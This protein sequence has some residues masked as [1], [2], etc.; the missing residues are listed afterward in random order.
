MKHLI[1]GIDGGTRRILEAYDMPFT[2]SL[3]S[4]AHQFNTSDEDLFS[5]GWAEMVLGEHAAETR[6]FYMAPLM[7]GSTGFSIK[8]KTDE[9]EGLGYTPIWRAAEQADLKVGIMNIPTTS[10]AKTVN[11]FMIGSGGGGVNKVSGIPDSLVY[12]PSAKETLAALNYIVDIRMTSSGIDNIEEL[13]EQLILKEKNRAEAFIKLAKDHQID[14]GF[15]VDRATTIV[16]YL[17]MSEIETRI[18]KSEMEEQFTPS[19]SVDQINGLLEQFYSSMDQNIQKL[20]ENL[21]PENWILTAD[22]STVSYKLKG[23]MTPFL[24]ENGYLAK[25]AKKT[26]PLALAKKSLLKFLPKKTIGNLR[27]SLPAGMVRLAHDTDWRRTRAFGHNYINGIYINDSR[28]G[29]KVPDTKIDSLVDEICDCFN[30]HE[31]PAKHNISAKPYRRNFKGR[32]C[33]DHLPDIILD[34]PDEFQCVGHGE[35]IRPNPNYGPIP[36]LS[37]VKEDMFTG[38]KGR[39]PLFVCNQSLAKLVE[40]E[41]KMDLTLVY[42]LSKRVFDT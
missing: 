38:Q 35:F 40:T 30:Q 33:A 1:F 42:K 5:R 41:D 37:E 36:D 17:C 26:S 28:F 31:T 2:K 21:K 20:F 12:P 27:K 14:F 9:G 13:F 3:L 16:Q 24:E 11:G 32:N 19:K 7:D 23:N 39:N 8:Y 25:R 22:H 34:K 18:L 15:L 4:E 6:A 29:G 10:P